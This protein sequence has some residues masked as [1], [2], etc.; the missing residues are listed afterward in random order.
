M[1]GIEILHPVNMLIGNKHQFGWKHDFY[2]HFNHA[3]TFLS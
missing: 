1:Y 3:A 2:S